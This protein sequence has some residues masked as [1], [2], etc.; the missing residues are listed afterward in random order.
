MEAI[1]V[2]LVWKIVLL[3]VAAAL[4]TLNYRMLPRHFDFYNIPVFVLAA[5]IGTAAQLLFFWAI[6]NVIQAYKDRERKH[7]AAGIIRRLLSK[8]IDFFSAFIIWSALIFACVLL[9][10]RFFDFPT[11]I[12]CLYLLC[13]DSVTKSGSMGKVWTGLQLKMLD[14]SKAR[15]PWHISAARNFYSTLFIILA[16]ALSGEESRYNPVL[17]WLF[18][19]VFVTALLDI[20]YLKKTGVRFLDQKL[21]VTVEKLSGKKK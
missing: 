4:F 12:T 11:L 13:C 15:C 1:R 2:K 17:N 7:G 16:V 18:L 5:V 20:I 9:Q 6:K 10:I 14:Q 8:G 3:L 21:G 19:V